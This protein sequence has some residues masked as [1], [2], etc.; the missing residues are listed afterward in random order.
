MA[1]GPKSNPL[2]DFGEVR[3]LIITRKAPPWRH[4]R[5]GSAPDRLRNVGPVIK[6]LPFSKMSKGFF[7]VLAPSQR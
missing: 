5:A 6:G 2:S 7:T 3:Q 1:N 4:D